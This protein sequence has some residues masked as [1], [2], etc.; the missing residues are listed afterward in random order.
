MLASQLLMCYCVILKKKGHLTF[1]PPWVVGQQF[2]LADRIMLW[3]FIVGTWSSDRIQWNKQA[4]LINHPHKGV[5]QT[6]NNYGHIPIGL[7]TISH[8]SFETGFWKLM[9][10]HCFIKFCPHK[11]L[12][13]DVLKLHITNH[14]GQHFTIG[15][16]VHMTNHSC[17]A[18]N[19]FHLIKHYPNVLQIPYRLHLYDEANSILDAI[20]RHITNKHLLS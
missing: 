17:L 20:Y 8:E 13:F 6:I 16:I 18:N 9:L 3:T 4:F 19:T 2:V 12:N 5:P 7:C 14:Y 15:R 1:L 11:S 10:Q